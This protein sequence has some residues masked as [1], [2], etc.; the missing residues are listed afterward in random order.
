MQSWYDANQTPQTGIHNE[1]DTR[2]ELRTY[3]PALFA[4]AESVYGDSDWRPSCP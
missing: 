1:I 2:E 4:I 3:D